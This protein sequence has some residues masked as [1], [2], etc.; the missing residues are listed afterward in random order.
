LKRSNIAHHIFHRRGLEIGVF[1]RIYRLLKKERVDIVHTHHFTQLFY[2]LLPAKFAGAKIVHTEHEYYSYL[3][4]PRSRVLIKLFSY[5]CDRFTVVGPEVADYF[6]RNIGIPKDRISIVPNGIDVRKFDVKPDGVRG[7]LGI[8][9]DEVIFA[10]VSRLEEE[11]DHRTLLNSFKLAAQQHPRIKLLIIGDGSL[12]NELQAYA[13]QIGVSDKVLFLGKR[14]EI[15]RFLS[16]TDVF[17]LSSIREGLPLSIMEAM[18]ARKP[19]ISTDVGSIRNLVHQKSN[20]LLVPA[21]DQNMLAD[22]MVCLI[23]SPKLRE[24]MGDRGYETVSKSF[25]L[26]QMMERYQ[27]IYYSLLRN[28]HVRN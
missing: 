13:H 28:R 15:P 2:S 16:E 17:V 24:E 26:V 6:I 9:K 18:A 5:F 4:S 23:Q 7:E 19:V 10:T 12:Q 27:D 22:A 25:S 8:P 14:S 20:G 1:N 11:K 21:G 3:E